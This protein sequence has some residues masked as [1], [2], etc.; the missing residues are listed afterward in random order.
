M[1]GPALT[2]ESDGLGHRLPGGRVSILRPCQIPTAADIVCVKFSNLVVKPEKQDKQPAQRQKPKNQT[3][4][5]KVEKQKASDHITH[6]IQLP[7]PG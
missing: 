2:P 3:N 4:Q 7:V 5:A 6:P 1:P